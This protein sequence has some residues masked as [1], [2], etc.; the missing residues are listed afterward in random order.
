MKVDPATDGSLSA[1]PASVTVVA[2]TC[3]K[4]DTWATALMVLGPGAGGAL[5]VRHS[6]EALFLL[7]EAGGIYRYAAG[8]LFGS[9]RGRRLTRKGRRG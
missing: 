2:P 5:A 8:T 7:R 3:A 1:P 6:L 9:G 4:A